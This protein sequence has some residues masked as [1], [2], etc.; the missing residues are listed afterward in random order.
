MKGALMVPGVPTMTYH[1]GSR[2]YVAMSSS[3]TK[4]ECVQDRE[5]EVCWPSAI[6]GVAGCVFSTHVLRAGL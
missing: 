3:G 4:C 5:E 2:S 1:H 6:G